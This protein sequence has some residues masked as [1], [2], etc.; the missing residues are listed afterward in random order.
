M[1]H[2]MENL[3]RAQQRLGR[4]AAPV[5]TDA[6]KIGLF[7]HRGLEA[8]LR[9]ADR[10]DVAAGTGAD[11]DDV[12]GSVGHGLLARSCHATGLL[13]SVIARSTCDE[14]TSLPVVRWIASL[15]SQ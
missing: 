5:E 11:D 10:G 14:A 1:L 15:R 8:E 2:V 7:D 13:V 4:D 9:R 12:E 3:G 6:A